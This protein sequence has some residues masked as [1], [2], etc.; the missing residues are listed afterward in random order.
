MVEHH[1]LPLVAVNVIVKV[2]DG[3]VELH[4]DTNAISR[5]TSSRLLSAL[6]LHVAQL[7]GCATLQNAGG[8]ISSV[9]GSGKRGNEF[10][11]TESGVGVLLFPPT[12]A[13]YSRWTW[14]FLI[15]GGNIVAR[16]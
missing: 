11:I 10:I 14:G 12:L 6:D 7:E 3:S 8:V 4:V 1:K 9:L 16:R 15:V 13:L 5:S 2:T